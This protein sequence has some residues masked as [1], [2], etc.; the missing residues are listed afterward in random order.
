MRTRATSTAWQDARRRLEAERA[1]FSD[2]EQ[3]AV[4]DAASSPFFGNVYICDAAFRGQE[5]GNA[6]PDPIVLNSLVRRR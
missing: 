3:V 6:A 1:L 2:H 4:D 5:K